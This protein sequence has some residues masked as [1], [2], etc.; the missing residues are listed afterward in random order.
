[1][2]AHPSARIWVSTR[3]VAGSDG[4]RYSNPATV[5]SAAQADKVA[6]ARSSAV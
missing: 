2:F 5:T 6:N 3:R 1:M 4:R